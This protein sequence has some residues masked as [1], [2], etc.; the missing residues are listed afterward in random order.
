[1][2]N[3][4][5]AASFVGTNNPYTGDRYYLRIIYDSVFFIWVGIVLMNII[6]GLMVDAFGSIREEAGNRA[7]TLET[8]CFVCGLSREAYEESKLEAGSP[9]WDE[10]LE[11]DHGGKNEKM[12]I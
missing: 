8:E 10:H 4:G 5:E 6:T 11:K 2:S 3:S 12:R 1:M 7:E 9:K